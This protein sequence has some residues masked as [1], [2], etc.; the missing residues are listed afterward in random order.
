MPDPEGA[1]PAVVAAVEEDEPDE[2]SALIGQARIA[3]P[4]DDAPLEVRR[5]VLAASLTNFAGMG[6]ILGQRFV[7]GI[8]VMALAASLAVATGL[9]RLRWRRRARSGSDQGS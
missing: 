6:L 3:S 7:P 1:A 5:L 4:A 2:L 9:M 8:V